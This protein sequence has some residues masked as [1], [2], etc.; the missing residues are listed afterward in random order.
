M[1]EI[2]EYQSQVEAQGPVGGTSPNLNQVTAVGRGLS[3]LGES[4][5][6]GADIMN[7][8]DTQAE[9]SNISAGAAQATS[10]WTTTLKQRL[11][12]ESLDV[13]Q[14]KQEFS[15][16]IG[17]MGENLETAGGKNYFQ[18]VKNRLEARMTT[19]AVLVQAAIKGRQMVDNWQSTLDHGSIATMADP[20]QFDTTYNNTV[21]G[22][23]ALISANPQ[24]AGHEEKLR[25]EAGET[26][27]VAAVKG[28]ADINPDT[29]RKMLEGGAYDQF[30]N[31]ERKEFLSDYIDKKER[32]NDVED[33]RADRAQEKAR[34]ATAEDWKAKNFTRLENGA[35]SV[36]EVEG[37]VNTGILDTKEGEE[38]IRQI[39]MIAKENIK[40]ND[41]FQQGVIEKIQ[42][43][44]YN[45][46]EDIRKLVGPGKLSVSTSG[47]LI[48]WMNEDP[49]IKEQVTGEKNLLA[50]AK[51]SLKADVP[52]AEGL[53]AQRYNQF[54]Q[55]LQTAKRTRKDAGLPIK[56]LTTP[57]NPAYMGNLL[58]TSQYRPSMQDQMAEIIKHQ[59]NTA[60]ENKDPLAK[61]PGETAAE[62]NKRKNGR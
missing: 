43:G 54:W 48:K 1:P 20:S 56:D 8:A 29:A 45:D 19:S 39:K 9:V 3:R 31:S 42:S 26:L 57:G 7:R 49:T 10:D 55:D 34:K 33:E 58:N 5:E 38:Q 37:A 6:Q 17:K 25:R 36:R 32:H 50:E 28:W 27:T 35:L 61:K 11:A 53:M 16:Y 2:K 14:F 59:T 40:G 24:L 23:N 47:K 41:S 44:E 62:W 21:D 4:V 12:N 22:I 30:L 52:G 51:K 13:D 46:P 18:K 60:I 15:D